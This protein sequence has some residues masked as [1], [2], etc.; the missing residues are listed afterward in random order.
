[1]K[2]KFQPPNLSNYTAAGIVDVCGPDQAEYNRLDKL[3]KFYKEGLKARLTDDMKVSGAPTDSWLVTG[4]QY[5]AVIE[6]QEPMYFDQSKA[7]ALLT[8]EQFESCFS[9]SPRLVIR[10][11]K[12][13][14]K[15]PPETE[16]PGGASDTLQERL[17]EKLRS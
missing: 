3:T 15:A 9:P 8:P 11:Q 13:P 6:T 16:T 2:S 5:Q 7:R 14:E 17:K 4:E 12:L 10:F 1:M